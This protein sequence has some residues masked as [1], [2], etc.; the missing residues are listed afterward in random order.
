MAEPMMEHHGAH[1]ADAHSGSAD[2]REMLLDMR[3]SWLW[4]N[5]AVILLGVSVAFSPATFGYGGVAAW[6]DVLAGVLIAAC[7]AAA[8]S[9][10]WDFYGRWGAALVGLWLQFAP[11]LFHPPAAGYLVDTMA[12]V[13]VVVLMVLVPMMPG[14]A[15]H[16]AMMQP[17]PEVPPGWTYCP[18]T[19]HQRVPMI[20]LAFIGWMISRYLAAYQLGYTSHVWDPFFGEQSMNVLT[21]EVSRM[22][23]VSDAGVGA[24]AYTIEMLMAW[25]GDRRRWR[26]MPWMVSFFF[27]LVVPLG[28]TH[29]VLVIMQPV[30]V[31]AWCFLCLA[32][33]VAMLL[34]IPFTID[35]VIATGQFLADRVRH[36]HSFWRTFWVGDTMTG[37]G[38]DERTP[39]YGARTAAHVTPAAW[40][41]SLPWTLGLSAVMGIWAIV[42]PEFLGS[43]GLLMDSDRI[44]GALIVTASV[45][46]TAEVVRSGRY[47]NLL[48]GAWLALSPFLLDGGSSASTAG[49]V[50]AGIAVALLALPRGPVY[51][52]YGSW[53]RWIR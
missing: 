22:W 28:V 16:M 41:V 11:L 14:M 32:A 21:S 13:L 45:V 36:G 9:P 17:G 6:N 43:T 42:T 48:F 29:V 4:T 27:L 50:A 19:W 24:F 37:G 3:R 44:T 49:N 38:P 23:P 20:V 8:L 33:A 47:V 31:G 1:K 53:D 52:R 40:G 10:T 5:G 51:E 15:H 30:M 18:S 25:M 2:H 34:M 39:K 35:E 12:G 26:T 46:V 7:A